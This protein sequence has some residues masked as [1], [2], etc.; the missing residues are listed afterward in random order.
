MS[1]LK[2][3]EQPEESP[4][5]GGLGSPAAAGRV[6]AGGV[7]LPNRAPRGPPGA[8]PSSACEVTGQDFPDLVGNVDS[9]SLASEEKLASVLVVWDDSNT[10][11]EKEEIF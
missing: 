6:E 8:A 11:P 9:G 3:Q 4:G 10:A 5:C 7:R 2:G 1:L